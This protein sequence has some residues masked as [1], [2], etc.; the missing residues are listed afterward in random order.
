MFW[1]DKATAN[2]IARLSLWRDVE[3]IMRDAKEALAK[4]RGEVE[5]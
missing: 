4:A 3:S 5:K 1:F 2:S